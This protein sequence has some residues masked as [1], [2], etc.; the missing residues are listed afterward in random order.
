[1]PP[2]SPEDLPKPL[3]REEALKEGHKIIGPEGHVQGPLPG[4]NP[5]PFDPHKQYVFDEEKY[6]Q[7]QVTLGRITPDEAARKKAEEKLKA[8]E[9]RSTDPLTGLKNR[10]FFQEYLNNALPLA[11]R[12]GSEMSIV[13]ADLDRFKLINDEHGHP[14][15][16]EMLK[17][18]A[19][20]LKNACRT[21][22]VVVRLGG[23]EFAIAMVNQSPILNP[24]EFTD[25]LRGTIADYLNGEN[26]RGKKRLEWLKNPQTTSIGFARTGDL[27]SLIDPGAT[28]DELASRIEETKVRLY[29]QADQAL[30]AAKHNGRDKSVVY[31]P[32][33]QEINTGK[34]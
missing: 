21:S 17:I 19:L 14:K 3:S 23:E 4:F 8:E 5:E 1:M 26:E 30:Y 13:I 12:S 18:F 2:K 31:D 16:D 34:N 24:Q 9:E 10:R 27:N 33:L 6:Y 7:E 20:A 29:E 15:G 25:N 11:A 22:D 28:K 32:S